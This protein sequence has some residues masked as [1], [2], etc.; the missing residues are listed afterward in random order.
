MASFDIILKYK[1]TPFWFW[2]YEEKKIRLKI[3]IIVSIIEMKLFFFVEV[4]KYLLNFSI[5]VVE[6]IIIIQ[7]IKPNDITFAAILGAP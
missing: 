6:K 5:Y 1:W 4:S 2:N 3:F 7:Y